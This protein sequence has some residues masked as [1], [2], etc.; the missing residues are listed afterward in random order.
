[1]G[2]K[3]ARLAVPV[4]VNVAGYSVD[5]YVFVVETLAQTPGVVAFE[6]NISCPNVR[7]GMV[8][9]SDPALAAEVTRAVR[10]ATDLPITVKLTPNAPDVV[11]AA[12]AVAEAGA[13]ARR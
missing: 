3:W 9:G 5:D 13:A 4:I 8:F 2:S 7:G 1:Y 12:R 6:L 11:A 10:A